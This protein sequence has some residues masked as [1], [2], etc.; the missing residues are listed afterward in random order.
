MAVR[1]K[2]ISLK[3]AQ[4]MQRAGWNKFVTHVVCCLWYWRA[5]LSCCAVVL[6]CVLVCF[7]VLWCF[8]VFWCVLMC[9]WCGL[10]CFSVLV[11]FDM[12]VGC[13]MLCCAVLRC[14]VLWCCAVLLCCA[15]LRCALLWCCGE[16]KF[17]GF[18][19]F[20]ALRSM[21]CLIL[22]APWKSGGSFESFWKLASLW[23][24]G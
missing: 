7:R 3:S 16:V 23:G 10:V 6:V 2:K 8:G 4:W 9:F 19:K 18:G 21:H 5:V 22:G 20:C 17:W 12:Y 11:C 13:V 15:M 14:A 24:V 1:T